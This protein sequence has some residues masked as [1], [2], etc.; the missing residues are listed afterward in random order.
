MTHGSFDRRHSRRH[1][2]GEH[3]IISARVRPGHAAVVIDV[4]AG[5][6]F[7]EI[8]QRLLPGAAVDLQIETAQRR[9]T[10]RG[11]VVRC[12]VAGLHSTMVCYRAAVA[13]D[14]QWPHLESEWSEY[15]IPAD[16]SRDSPAKRVT[17]THDLA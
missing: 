8:P 15:P 14:H 9:T 4:S 3:G 10:V 2:I 16:E 13:F 6:A 1:G 12:S 7:M 11:R 17:T 5:G